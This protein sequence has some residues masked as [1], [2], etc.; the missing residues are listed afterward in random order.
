MIEIK[1]DEIVDENGEEVKI[2]VMDIDQVGGPV[3][4]SIITSKEKGA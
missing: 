3:T 4:M 1:K 2:M